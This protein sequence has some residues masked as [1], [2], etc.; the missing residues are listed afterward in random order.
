MS[1]L[2][3]V[4]LNFSF[5][6]G[7]GVA[8]ILNAIAAA[9]R[10]RDHHALH[11]IPIAWALLL[12]FYHVQFWFGFLRLATTIQTWTWAW[13]MYMLFL[14]VLLYVAGALVLPGRGTSARGALRED[15]ETRGRSAL[16]PLAIYFIGWIPPNAEIAGGHGLLDIANLTLAAFAG[17]AW[18]P[19]QSV[20]ALATLSS[21]IAPLALF[22]IG[23]YA[24]PEVGTGTAP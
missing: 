12:F 4:T 9:F 16:I 19:Q 23:T 17:L 22:A 1:T 11:W 7:L 15:F 21:L 10:E 24:G 13:Y 14:A 5:V 3:I 6:L 2:E 18:M 8:Q 20:R